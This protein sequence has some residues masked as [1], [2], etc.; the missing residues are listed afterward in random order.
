MT[1]ERRTK[2]TGNNNY[3]QPHDDDDLTNLVHLGDK[4]NLTNPPSQLIE[5][6][7]P[8]NRINIVGEDE[9]EMP[10]KAY[11][12]RKFPDF[13]FY[14][15]SSKDLFKELVDPER[16]AMLFQTPLDNFISLDALNREQYHKVESGSSLSRQS[17]SIRSEHTE[18]ADP[19]AGLLKTKN[20]IS[21]FE[22]DIDEL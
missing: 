9:E 7:R 19:E 11:V 10:L 3:F 14:Q 15:T 17:S 21:L 5:T 18:I 2:F 6:K 1:I 16:E 4:S 22:M 13:D 8:N 12:N 20:A